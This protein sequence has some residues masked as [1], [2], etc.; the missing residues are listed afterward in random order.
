MTDPIQRMVEYEMTE[1]DWDLLEEKRLLQD[2]W[3]RVESLRDETDRAIEAETLTLYEA[4][5]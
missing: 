1:S 3:Q 5:R 4:L 2:Y